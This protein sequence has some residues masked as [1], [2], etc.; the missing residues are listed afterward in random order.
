MKLEELRKEGAGHGSWRIA[1]RK[2]GSDKSVELS[3]GFRSLKCNKKRPLEMKVART[4]MRDSII[5]AHG[6][7][8]GMMT[9]ASVEVRQ[10][11]GAQ[12]DSVRTEWETT[13]P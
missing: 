4:C 3:V 10:V 13:V 5:F 2:Q 7:I 12:S 1:C 9:R 6:T 11:C 8:I